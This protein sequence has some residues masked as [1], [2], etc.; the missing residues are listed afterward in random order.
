[1]VIYLDNILIFA[2][3]L[4][5]L[6]WLTH[7]VLQWLQDLDLFLWPAKCSFNQ[8]SVKYL[9]LIISEG[10]LRMDPVKL[11][12]IWDWPH[13][14]K[15]KDIQKFLGFCNFYRH[16]VWNYSQLAWPLFDLTRKETPF[17]WMPTQENAFWQLQD[18][19]T[20]SPVLILLDYEKPF[21]LITDASDFAAGA[22]LEQEDALGWSHP[23]TF[24]SKSLQP[25]EWNYE[26]HNKEL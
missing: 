4:L 20:S 16:F 15:V 10:E 2:T 17:L 1:M 14:K 18:T 25:A 11:Q 22:I 19:L 23:I 5:E 21:M 26:I 12:A 8:T 3:T 6:E 7:L 9:G 24:F 13:P